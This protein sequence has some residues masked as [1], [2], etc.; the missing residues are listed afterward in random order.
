MLSQLHD[1]IREA[2]IPIVGIG[3]NP[4]M[5][6]RFDFP[7][8][9]SPSGEELAECEAIAQSFTPSPIPQWDEF[10]S[11]FSLPGNTLYASVATKV[12]AAGFLAQ[13]HW[14]NFKLLLAT[15]AQRSPVTLTASINYLAQLLASAGQALSQTDIEGWNALMNSYDFPAS[16]QL[17]LP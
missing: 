9:Y 10:L 1:Q 12:A 16:C 2:G 15:E 14:A 8:N 6:Y 5:S 4:D 17:P 3:Y 7:A 11:A 13:D